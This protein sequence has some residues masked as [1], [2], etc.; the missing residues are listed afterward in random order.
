MAV[1]VPAHHR[2]T[3]EEWDRLGRLAFF[4][5]DDR[6]ELID[7]EIVDMTPIED[8]HAESVTALVRLLVR[9]GR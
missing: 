5:E 9:L 7:G 3:V 1:A 8:R 4:S 6:V 2:F